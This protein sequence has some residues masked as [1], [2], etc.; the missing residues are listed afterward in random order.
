MKSFKAFL[1]EGGN[2][3][4]GE[5]AAGPINVTKKNRAHVSTD[6]HQM[7]SAVHDSFH[8]E[9]GVHLFGPK[10][11]ALHNGSIY[12]GSTEHLM[13]H[14]ISHEEFAKHKPKVGDVDVKV[15]SEHYDKVHDHM[16]PGKKFGKYTVL[17]TKKSGSESHALMQHESGDI[18]QVDFEKSE[19]HK[20]QPAKY[21]HF[22]HSGDWSDTKA[23]IKG[24]HHKFLVNASGGETHKFSVAKGLKTRDTAPSEDGIKDTHKITKTLFG[25]DADEK[26]LHSFQGVADLIK[27]HKSVDEHHAIFNKFVSSTKAKPGMDHEPAIKHLAKTLGIHHE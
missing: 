12:S 25:K 16:Q 23:G 17:G 7:L 18:H 11:E 1:A 5:L 15:P 22:A 24:V 8:K 13:N 20:G 26:K 27:K 6:I 14:G 21:E 9:H 2:V 3:K 10:K 4:I 19:Y